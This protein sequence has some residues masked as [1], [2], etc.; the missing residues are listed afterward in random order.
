MRRRRL[1]ASAEDGKGIQMKTVKRGK[2]ADG[3]EENVP[4]PLDDLH[5]PYV[6]VR[7]QGEEI[8]VFLK[9]LLAC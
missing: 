6:Q 9:L 4:S 2:G 7:G 8:I 1:P 3:D 5:D